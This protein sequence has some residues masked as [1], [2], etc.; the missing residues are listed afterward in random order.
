M[1]TDRFAQFSQRRFVEGPTR[2]FGVGL[3]ETQRYYESIVIPPDM[4]G[5]RMLITATVFHFDRTL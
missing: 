5:E 3:Y 1:F 4:H 2:L